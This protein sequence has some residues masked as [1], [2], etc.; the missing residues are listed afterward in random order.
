MQKL[1]HF[2]PALAHRLKPLMR[3][4][5]QCTGMLFQPHIDGGITRDSAV[6]SQQ[7]RS[8]HGN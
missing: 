6:E 3:D 5:S 1:P 7:F 4:G 2:V 8:L